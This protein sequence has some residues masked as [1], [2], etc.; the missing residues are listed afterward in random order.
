MT[1]NL[2]ELVKLLNSESSSNLH[3][4]L[5]QIDEF[6]RQNSNTF[7]FPDYVHQP[8]GTSSALVHILKSSW[9]Y[10]NQ[11]YE[12][13]T[14]SNFHEKTENLL[15]LN[16]RLLISCLDMIR[17]VSRD[18][19]AVTLFEETNLLDLVQQIANL[20]FQDEATHRGIIIKINNE[21]IESINLTALKSISNLIYNSKFVQEFY[22]SNGLAD[23][24][25]M[26]LKQF[27]LS[28]T[29][30]CTVS[31]NKLNIMIFNL[32]IL[33]LL[34]VFNKDL[35]VKLR[36]K[37]QVITYLIEII[38]QIM[39]ERLNVN[40]NP[41][42][43]NDTCDYCYL[44]TTDIDFVNEILKILYNLT[45]DLARQSLTSPCHNNEEEEAHLMHLVS[46]LRDLMTCRLE[47]DA[48]ISLSST[49][50]LNDLHSNIVNLLTNMPSICFEELMTPCTSHGTS[51]STSSHFE[52]I[53]NYYSNVRLAHNKKRQSRRSK[54]LRQ[55]NSN[56]KKTLLRI[57]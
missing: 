40:E 24:I 28:D 50:K 27:S 32:R 2:T 7:K 21:Q 29:L 57:S 53:N 45:M 12:N 31:S 15:N 19:A 11:T 14:S 25:T 23:A 16:S 8:T 47:Q 49:D 22:A 4:I 3:K 33:F 36:E 34:T 54:R 35:R 44:N 17:L 38:D 30:G 10:L 41:S 1:S 46:V 20:S 52:Q 56:K 37:L 51:A 5:D 13:D 26:C 55:S 18:T 43:E 39:K 9:S 6:N 48:K 42:V